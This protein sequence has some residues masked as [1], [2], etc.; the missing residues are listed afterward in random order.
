MSTMTS[1]DLAMEVTLRRG[2]S[3]HI[4][5]PDNIPGY[6]SDIA[7]VLQCSPNQTKN[8]LQAVDALE[9]D[10]HFV[11][12]PPVEVRAKKYGSKGEIIPAMLRVTIIPA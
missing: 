12:S 6:E 4:F 9:D 11:V 3:F 10:H 8:L 1:G 5:K 7:K 2:V